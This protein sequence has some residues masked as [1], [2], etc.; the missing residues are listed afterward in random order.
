M[1]LRFV[2]DNK[3]VV[4]GLIST[5][6]PDLE[7]KDEIKRRIE[8]AARHVPLSQLCLSPQCGFSSAAGGGQVLTMDDTRRK[9]E[10]MQDIAADVWGSSR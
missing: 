5:K 9:I 1:P 10:L 4:L 2:P 3:I 6:T 8:E 7:S